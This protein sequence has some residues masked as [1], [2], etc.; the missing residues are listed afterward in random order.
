MAFF[1]LP[2]KDSRILAVFVIQLYKLF[3][4]LGGGGGG[5]QK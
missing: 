1:H 2:Q 5:E 3:F 4:F